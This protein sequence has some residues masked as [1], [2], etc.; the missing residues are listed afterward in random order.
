[1]FEDQLSNVE[2]T[3]SL[4]VC[5]SP[6]ASASN[7]PV[8]SLMT[9]QPQKSL[10]QLQ[11]PANEKESTMLIGSPSRGVRE[12]AKLGSVEGKGYKLLKLDPNRMAA[13]RECTEMSFPP[14]ENLKWTE[15]KKS[16][17]EKCK[18]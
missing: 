15:I 17:D 8:S 7:S 6:K 2:L 3:P 14:D 9:L 11:K 13:V 12:E 18:M 4:S 16:I 10:K 5:I 1:S